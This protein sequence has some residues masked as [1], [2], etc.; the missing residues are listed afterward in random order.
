MLKPRGSK[1]FENYISDV[2]YQTIHSGSVL[3]SVRIID[4]FWNECI[5][6]NLKSSER[7]RRSY[8]IRRGV[9]R[10]LRSETLE[11]FLKSR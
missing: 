5:T 3:H 7:S 1:T 2:T 4:I 11:K 10:L 6:D 9:I 8:G